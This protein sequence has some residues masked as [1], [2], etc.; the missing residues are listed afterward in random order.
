MEPLP[1]L[2]L[3]AAFLIPFPHYLTALLM[4]SFLIYFCISNGSSL[5]LLPLSHHLHLIPY[6]ATTTTSTTTYYSSFC[7]LLLLSLAFIIIFTMIYNCMEFHL[8]GDLLTGFRGHSAR[9]KFHPHSPLYHS[10]VSR[11]S[12]L[13]GRYLATPWLASPHLQTIFMSFFG[14]PPVVKYTRELFHTS[15]GATIA[16]DWLRNSDDTTPKDDETPTVIVIPG[17]ASDSDSPY[18]KHLALKIV[19]HGWNVCVNNHRGFGGVPLTSD[20]LCNAGWTEDTREVINHL[21]RRYPKAPLYAVGTSVGANILVK[22]LGEEGINVPV[23]GA[24]AIC[25]PWD[26]VVFDRFL[27]RSFVQRLYDKAI[28]I[29]LQSY[30]ELHRSVIS[31]LA[32]LKAI[33]KSCSLREFYGNATCFIGNHKTLDAYYR[34]SSCA[35]FVG[36][37]AVPLLCINALD[38]PI[39]PVEAIPWDKCRANKNIILVS[40]QHGGHIAHYEGAT[41]N[42]MWWVRAVVE[43]LGVLHSTRSIHKKRCGSPPCLTH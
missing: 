4:N 13:H 23:V 28:M 33:K 22:Y 26:L 6:T 19:K 9:L 3:R 17:L 20:R 25:S 27:N 2:L 12:I 32:D 21:H 34:H 29:S 18:I 8:L 30:A 41:A 16:L 31:R 37:V 10:V 14:R 5:L 36:N 43:F 24:A 42:S 40:T 39:C 7:Y 11:C 1:K 15:D 35:N 38:D